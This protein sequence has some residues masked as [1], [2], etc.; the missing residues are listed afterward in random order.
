MS[1]YGALIVSL[2]YNTKLPANGNGTSNPRLSYKQIVTYSDGTTET[3]TSGGNVV[4]TSA[5]GYVNSTSGVV[6]NS[7]PNSSSTEITADTVTVTVTLNDKTG[8]ATSDVKQLGKTASY[9]DITVALS[10]PNAIPQNGNG[11][12]EPILNYSQ[13]VTYTDGTT[14][15]IT[16]GGTVSYRS[17]QNHVNATTGVVSG[18]GPNTEGG[19]RVADKVTVTVELNGKTKTATA[20]VM[21]LSKSVSGYSNVTVNLLYPTKISYDGSGTSS[22]ELS[23]SQIIYYSDGTT[24]SVTTGGTVSYSSTN[25]L[26]D[27]ASGDVSGASAN[28]DP[29]DRTVDTVTATVALNGKTGTATANVKQIAGPKYGEITI[30]SFEYPINVPAEGGNSIPSLNYQQTLTLP[31]GTTEVKTNDPSATKSF[32]STNNLVNATSGV[33]TKNEANDVTYVVTVDTVTVTVSNGGM[34]ASRSV[35]VKQDAKELPK[36]TVRWITI[37]T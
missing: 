15:T 29:N 2:S 27:A 37:D 7:A 17:T 24:G 19:D 34:S 35:I 11:S 6:S 20:D 14:E 9:S 23:Y 31:D 25:H 12:S 21:Q 10:Y 3:I 36:H 22:P 1:E 28:P 5:N 4:Y 33:V 32:S 26:V 13:V 18:V 8:T 30:T 16:S